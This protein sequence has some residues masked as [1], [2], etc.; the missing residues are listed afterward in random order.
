M[1]EHDVPGLLATSATR[2]KG[3]QLPV[4][5]S[6]KRAGF[7]SISGNLAHAVHP[8]GRL[9]D[10]VGDQGR[11]HDRLGWIGDGATAEADFHTALIFASRL[12]A[13]R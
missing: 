2:C 12:P 7:F 5:Y 8:G 9:G 11:H 13:R 6:C 1:V 3:R 10:G 4:M